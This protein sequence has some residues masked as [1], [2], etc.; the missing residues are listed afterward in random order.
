VS[1]GLRGYSLFPLRL[2]I[3]AYFV[4]NPGIHLPPRPIQLDSIPPLPFSTSFP[5]SPSPSPPARQR[6]FSLLT[7]NNVVTHAAMEKLLQLHK[8]RSSSSSKRSSPPVLFSFPSQNPLSSLPLPPPPPSTAVASYILYPSL[9]GGHSPPHSHS[10][11]S[12]PRSTYFAP[13][14]QPRSPSSEP[15]DSHHRHRSSCSSS[16]SSSSPPTPSSSSSPYTHA[17]G[18]TEGFAKH[19]NKSNHSKKSKASI[20]NYSRPVISTHSAFSFKSLS[21]PTRKQSG[22]RSPSSP[23]KPNVITTFTSEHHR[24]SASMDRSNTHGRHLSHH[25]ND[26]QSVRS[27]RTSASGTVSEAG[28]TE[29]MSLARPRTDQEIE[30]RFVDF[31]V[32]VN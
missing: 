14:P 27:H 29:A 20:D 6:P 25:D 31:M 26:A 8:K 30:D 22:N 3:V 5:S 10:P 15:V 21:S 23:T 19:N 32:R 7:Q 12:L 2:P 9:S 13:Q 17:N 28:R 1:S 24:A 11:P 16:S 18:A 4:P